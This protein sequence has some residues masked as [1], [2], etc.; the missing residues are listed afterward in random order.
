MRGWPGQ[1]TT[2]RDG[3]PQVARARACASSGQERQGELHFPPGRDT[4]ATLHRS[5]SKCCAVSSVA[6]NTEA[7][8]AD[9]AD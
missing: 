7:E 6:A 1:G 2:S 3:N 8:T 5:R 4:T 9:A